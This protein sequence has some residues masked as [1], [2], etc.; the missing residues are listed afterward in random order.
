MIYEFEFIYEPADENLPVKKYDAI[1][2][3]KVIHEKQYGQD[4][5][6]GRGTSVD[7]VEFK[8]LDLYDNGVLVKPEEYPLIYGKAVHEYYEYHKEKAL[9]WVMY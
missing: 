5:D 8:R 2:H 3:N 7:F 1:V 9:L 4:A 6:G